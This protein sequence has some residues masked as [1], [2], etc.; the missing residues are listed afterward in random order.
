MKEPSATVKRNLSLGVL[1][2]LIIIGL[3]LGF[4]APPLLVDIGEVERGDFRIVVEEE[5]E[6]RVRDRYDVTAPVN[7]YLARLGLEPGD[8]VDKGDVLFVVHPPPAEPLDNRSR[9]QLHHAL[10]RADRRVQ[11]ARMEKE[12]AEARAELAEIELERT[13]RLFRQDNVPREALDRARAEARSSAATLRSSQFNVQV[14]EFEREMVR[15]SLE[16]SADVDRDEPVEVRAP[17]AGTLLRRERESEGPVQAGQPILQLGDLESMEARIEVLSTDAVALAPDMRVEMERWGGDERLEGHIRR[18]DPAGFTR[19]SALGVEEQRVPVIVALEKLP[20]AH[21]PGDGFRV[22]ARF[23][24]E[25]DQDVLQ[26]PAA[27]LFREQDQW[28]VW[29]SDN[30]RARYREV[31]PGRRSG[32]MREVLDGLQ[33][34]EEVVLHP[35]DEMEEGRRLRR[36]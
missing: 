35:D 33:P 11:A 31:T 1:A 29:V 17:V 22:E 6:T 3:A 9:D 30:D 16:A 21:R 18:V 26:V 34:G 12:A 14:A 36:R 5:G 27:A 23:V 8:S 4:R 13:E 24:L 10:E 7:G 28:A 25:E 32:L 15:A 19:V 20:S 2:A